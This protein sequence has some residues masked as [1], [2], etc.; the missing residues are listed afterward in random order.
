M[1]RF[2]W[3]QWSR[4]LHLLERGKRQLDLPVYN[5]VSLHG[6]YLCGIIFQTKCHQ[7]WRYTATVTVYTYLLKNHFDLQ[8]SKLQSPTISESH[9]LATLLGLLGLLLF[10][11]WWSFS[12]AEAIWQNSMQRFYL[13]RR[14]YTSLYLKH[15]QAV[16]HNFW[17]IEEASRFSKTINERVIINIGNK[18]PYLCIFVTKL[19]FSIFMTKC[20]DISWYV[21]ICHAMPWYVW[22]NV[23][24][25]FQR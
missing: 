2:R 23:A 17:A 22:Q 8:S 20:H 1:W 21:M 11:T 13:V 15:S 19:M 5:E 25:L 12:V 10:P 14:G 3:L 18:M 9:D 24:I 16:W 6:D 7:I 4:L